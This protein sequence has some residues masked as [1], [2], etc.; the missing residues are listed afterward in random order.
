MVFI[1]TFHS[2]Y[3][4][5]NFEKQFAGTG[6]SFILRPVPREISS[7]CGIAAQVTAEESRV[8][9]IWEACKELRVETEALYYFDKINGKANVTLIS[10][11]DDAE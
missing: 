10:S 5:L 2:V 11:S 7:S 1:I 3:Q 9:Q 6:L 8:K 4:A